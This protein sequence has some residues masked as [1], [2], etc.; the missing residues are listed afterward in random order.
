[1]A[2]DRFK[3][4]VTPGKPAKWASEVTTSADELALMRRGSRLPWNGE[5][6]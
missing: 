6:N 1:M 4:T 5:G 3:E 2:P